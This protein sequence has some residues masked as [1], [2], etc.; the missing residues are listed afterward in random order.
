MITVHVLLDLV[1]VLLLVFV[2][3]LKTIITIEIIA[4]PFKLF[5]DLG[6]VPFEKLLTRLLNKLIRNLFG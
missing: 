6:G 3:H 4:L 5:L 2:G 1:E